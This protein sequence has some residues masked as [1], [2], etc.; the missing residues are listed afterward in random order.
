MGLAHEWRW[1]VNI[2]FPWY[3]DTGVFYWK[4]LL[5]LQT[6]RWNDWMRLGRGV[7]HFL[8]VA[9][10]GGGSGWAS[11]NSLIRSLQWNLIH[12]HFIAMYRKSREWLLC[13]WSFISFGVKR[14]GTRRAGPALVAWLGCCATLN[15][16]DQSYVIPLFTLKYLNYY[17]TKGCKRF[18]DYSMSWHDPETVVKFRDVRTWRHKS[19]LFSLRRPWILQTFF[20]FMTHKSRISKDFLGA[21]T[22]S[23]HCRLAQ[24]PSSGYFHSRA[25]F[26][27]HFA[28]F[29]L[30]TY[31]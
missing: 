5:R 12:L 22:R 18:D 27:P 23:S 20:V 29:A 30:I 26:V 14:Q 8:E 6:T 1:N 16:S 15:W 2:W 9:S 10:Y 31:N 28:K 7:W 13:L 19:D 4:S 17:S 24:S 25:R 21:K 11:L 3:L